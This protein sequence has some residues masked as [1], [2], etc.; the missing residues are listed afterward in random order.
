ML[1]VALDRRCGADAGRFARRCR[2]LQ[3][4][5][6]APHEVGQIIDLLVRGVTSVQHLTH[7]RSVGVGQEAAL[8]QEAVLG[9]ARLHHHRGQLDR[10]A[11][12]GQRLHQGLQRVGIAE[13]GLGLAGQQRG[14]ARCG[15]AGR[16][17]LAGVMSAHVER[18]GGQSHHA[19]RKQRPNR[20]PQRGP[21][22]AHSWPPRFMALRK[23]RTSAAASLR[24]CPGLARPLITFCRAMS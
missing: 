21:L 9:R 1:A 23:R 15:R 19:P 12:L 4:G 22:T 11:L 5:P 2:E 18:R 20:G 14:V 7:A 16:G 8:A 24:A 10:L 6:L 17:Q 3:L 13:G